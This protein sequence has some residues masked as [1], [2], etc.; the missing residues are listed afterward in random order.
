MLGKIFGPVIQNLSQ[1]IDPGTADM[2]GHVLA[3]MFSFFNSGLLVVG[4]IIISYVTLMGA[5]HT[6]NDGEAF[7]KRWSSVW[8]PMR[9]V[10]G[11][12]VLLPT[13]SGFSFIQ[14]FV[15]M[16]SLWSIGFANG[17]YKAGI[18]AGILDS[19]PA[20][21]SDVLFQNNGITT[22]NTGNTEPIGSH[23]LDEF[24]KKYLAMSYC[25]KVVNA[26]YA[27]DGVSIQ[28][29]TVYERGKKYGHVQTLFF[30]L[31]DTGPSNLAGG[32]PICGT[33]TL[34]FPT[35]GIGLSSDDPYNISGKIDAFRASVMASQFMQ[36]EELINDIDQWVDSD[37][38]PTRIDELKADTLSSSKLNDLIENR[39]KAILSGL[40]Q[41]SESIKLD[42]P[43]NNYVTSITKDG[44][45]N[46]G[47]WYQKIGAIRTAMNQS[48]SQNMATATGPALDQLPDSPNAEMVQ[49][50]VSNITNILVAK[51][52]NQQQS[53]QHLNYS[54]LQNFIPSDFSFSALK[55][56]SISEASRMHNNCTNSITTGM[57]QS[58]VSTMVGGDSNVDA[59]TRMKMTGDTINAINA[60]VE[61]AKITL[62][63]IVTAIRV[64]GGALS[65]FVI[66]AEGLNL[67]RIAT[68]IWDWVMAVPMDWI[69]SIIMYL[70]PL[71]FY[72]SIFLPM[73]PYTVFMITVVGWILA[74][75][76]SCVA[77]PLWAVMHM[78]PSETFIGSD[79][80]GYLL[81]LALFVRPALAVIGLFA[82]MVIADPVV[83]FV[84]K[85]FFS[86]SG[87]IGI[88]NGSIFFASSAFQQAQMFFWTLGLFGLTL[89][90]ILYMIFGLPQTLPDHVL[91]W[92]NAGVHD[93]GAT[94]ATAEMQRGALQ[95]S[96][97]PK[98]GQDNPSS[99]RAS[100]A[101]TQGARGGD[102]AREINRHDQAKNL[103][104]VRQ[105]NR[106]RGNILNAGQEGVAPAENDGQTMTPG[107]SHSKPPRTEPKLNGQGGDNGPD[108]EQPIWNEPDLG[109]LSDNSSSS[110]SS[111]NQGA[112]RNNALPFKEAMAKRQLLSNNQPALENKKIQGAMGGYQTTALRLNQ[113][114]VGNLRAQRG[115]QILSDDN[116]K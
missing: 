38:F 20:L 21:K 49:T 67:D 78:R 45:A 89:L 104:R 99:D 41:T 81:L 10:S 114:S 101:I 54:C 9:I 95:N 31:K 115:N 76:Q 16:I 4:T 30:S 56:F 43:L 72:F 73:L 111:E 106:G 62:L 36:T 19:G 8:T 40:K 88:N 90:P 52:D 87:A 103:A 17:I 33:V 26:A 97:A 42:E 68:P 94:Q 1:G 29:N 63:T 32:A 46:A 108:H 102:A 84:V 35:S 3:S 77:A 113:V 64:G 39:R 112:P 59:I 69:S 25:R 66:G 80:Q 86:S 91:R 57:Q 85:S 93:L 74:V 51:A 7:G 24:A 105:E 50:T 13:A 110:S 60:N 55:A 28:R 92:I 83:D 12:M 107:S 5:A 98:I 116:K 70:K 27:N 58:I 47:G 22:G 15:L 14:L 75:L 109:I 48:L 96:P 44:W 37:A 61:T 23:G 11:A 65:S 71:G 100:S 2:T 6:A 18:E 79:S 34:Q 53:N 82:A